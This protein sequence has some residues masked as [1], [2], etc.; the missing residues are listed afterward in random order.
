MHA[1]QILSECERRRYGET[2]YPLIEE[3]QTYEYPEFSLMLVEVMDA[4]Y[5]VKAEQ[6]LLHCT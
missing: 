6:D 3:G 4:F 1:I 2:I 5:I